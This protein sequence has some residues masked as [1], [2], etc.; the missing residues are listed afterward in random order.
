MFNIVQYKTT[1]IFFLHLLHPSAN[2]NNCK[3]IWRAKNYE[4][5]Y[6]SRALMQVDP[7][8]LN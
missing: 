5:P 8:T 3:T 1:V 2:E 6:A 4:G 7:N